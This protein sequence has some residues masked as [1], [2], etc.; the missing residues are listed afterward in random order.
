MTGL[1]KREDMIVKKMLFIYNPNAGTGTLK[2]RLSDVIDVFTKAGYEVTAYPTQKY[3]DATEKMETCL[4]DVYACGDIAEFNGKIIGL[5]Q[6]AMEQGKIAGANICGDEVVYKEQVQPLS[7]EGMHTG[8]LSI[9]D[10]HADN[11]LTDYVEEYDEIKKIYKKLIFK[12]GI[13]IGAI[14][15]G[16]TSKSVAVMK[17]VKEGMRKADILARLY[18]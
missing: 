16:D 11:S 7:F 17:G 4:P 18:N 3:R 9:G 14:L 12:N 13:L 1:Y 2:P 5:W 10:V 15:I 6:V 8:L